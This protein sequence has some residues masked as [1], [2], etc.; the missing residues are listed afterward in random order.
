ME[1]K[2]AKISRYLLGLM[3]LL[4]GLNKF[5]HFIPT[6]PMEGGSLDFMTA[7]MGTG[8]MLPLIAVVE[9][10]VGILLV[11]NRFVPLALVLMAPVSLNIIMFHLF[12]DP[13]SIAGG[14]LVTLLNLYL[15]IAHK[16]K[17]NSMLK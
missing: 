8:Y 15:L 13:A 17:Y 1:S 6:P 12:L 7:L 16:A 5:L 4:F 3:L 9:I 14:A 2:L 10:V 11:L